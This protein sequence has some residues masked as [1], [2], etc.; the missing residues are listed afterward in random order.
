MKIFQARVVERKLKGQVAKKSCGLLH[1]YVENT[2]SRHDHAPDSNMLTADFA[3]SEF[4]DTIKIIHSLLP[5]KSSRVS[6][7]ILATYLQSAAKVF[8]S[9]AVELAARWDE[10]DLPRLRDEVQFMITKIRDFASSADFD[11]QERVSTLY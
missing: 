1:G 7:D 4:S 10:D 2:A 9:W 5:D 3:D 11:L 8:G 6:S